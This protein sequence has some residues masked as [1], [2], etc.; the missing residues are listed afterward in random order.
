M[1]NINKAMMALLLGTSGLMAAPDAL[2]VKALYAQ[3]CGSCH[4]AYQA[5]FLPKRSWDKMME[6]LGDHFKTDAS[7]DKETALTLRA[8]LRDNASDGK[9]LGSKHMM[10]LARSI[11]QTQIPLR[12]SETPYFTKKH[13]EIPQKYITQEAVKSIA[14]CT[15]C[16][17]KAAQGEYGERGIFIPN[18]GR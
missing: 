7:L 5:Q 4:M 6:T 2:H 1:K 14:N 9:V 16:H 3:E 18:H 12:I 17:Q 10:K 15:A 13:R 8:Y 11:S